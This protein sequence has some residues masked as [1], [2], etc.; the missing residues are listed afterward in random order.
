MDEGLTYKTPSIAEEIL[1]EKVA[2]C[3][4]TARLIGREAPDRSAFN[5]S[6]ASQSL[7]HDFLC[8]SRNL[9]E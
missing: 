1:S 6:M 9:G 4:Q 8:Q 2:A 3:G 5:L 7:P